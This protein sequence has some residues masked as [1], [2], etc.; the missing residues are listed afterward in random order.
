MQC[1]CKPICG[2]YAVLIKHSRVLVNTFLGVG[3]FFPTVHPR[4]STSVDKHQCEVLLYTSLIIRLYILNV[5]VEVIDTN[6]VLSDV[7]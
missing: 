3:G 1:L 5:Q 7:D 2:V 4:R 6:F